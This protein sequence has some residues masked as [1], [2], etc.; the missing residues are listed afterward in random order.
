MKSLLQALLE[1]LA[2]DVTAGLCTFAFFNVNRTAGLLMLPYLGWL[3]LATA[4]NY[5]IYRD[6]KAITEKKD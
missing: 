3:S 5:V 1:L 4:L 6:N 2:L